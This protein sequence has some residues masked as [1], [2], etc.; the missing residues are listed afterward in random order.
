MNNKSK[1]LILSALTIF[2]VVISA[3]SW[4][5]YSGRINTYQ[6][7][8]IRNANNKPIDFK[9]Y[10]T[11]PFGRVF[12]FVQRD[13]LSASCYYSFCR[14]IEIRFQADNNFIN[15]N[16][17]IEI[18]NTK[19]SY[20]IIGNNKFIK[21]VLDRGDINYCKALFSVLQWYIFKLI[22]KI[23]FIAAIIFLLLLK[24]KIIT[25][26]IK[27]FMILLIQSIKS[28]I[29]NIINIVKKISENTKVQKQNII[30]V[31]LSL[32]NKIPF[33]SLTILF[34]IIALLPFLYLP[35]F[36]FPTPEEIQISANAIKSNFDY[37]SF[38]Y[39]IKDGRFFT[40][41][42]YVISPLSWHSIFGYRLML[43]I[44]MISLW[45]SI[46]FFLRTVFN[47][48][49]NQKK[50][51]EWTLLLIVMFTCL[52]PSVASGY[53]WL[54]AVITYLIPLI[55][56]LNLLSLIIINYNK[57]LSVLKLAV[58]SI[59]I[60]IICGSHEIY[61]PLITSI[62][63]LLTV[64]LFYNNNIN[65]W[66]FLFLFLLSLI[67]VYIVLSAPGH[68]NRI[69][70]NHSS[71][72]KIL[73]LFGIDN[74]FNAVKFAFKSVYESFYRY[75]YLNPIILFLSLLSIPTF[76]KIKTETAFLSRIININPLWAILACLL[77]M[78]LPVMPYFIVGEN[79]YLYMNRLFNIICFLFIFAWFYNI[80]VIIT[81]LKKHKIIQTLYEI[82]RKT[83]SIRLLKLLLIFF[84]IAYVFYTQNNI[85]VAYRD[86]ISGRISEYERQMSIRFRKTNS[87]LNNIYD[88]HSLLI[89]DAISVKPV[90]IHYQDYDITGYN[91]S[92]RE[93]VADY[94]HVNEVRYYSDTIPYKRPLFMKKN[95]VITYDFKSISINSNIPIFGSGLIPSFILGLYGTD[96]LT[97]NWFLYKDFNFGYSMYDSTL[98]IFSRLWIDKN[99]NE[100]IPVITVKFSNIKGDT[101]YKTI[102]D[103]LK[104]KVLEP[105]SFIAYDKLKLNHINSIDKSFVD[106]ILENRITFVLSS[107]LIKPAK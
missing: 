38:V 44:C 73:D 40:S 37:M 75:I 5:Y 9:V 90:S 26:S 58:F 63:F 92:F 69:Q 53:Y 94:F 77:L 2:F 72:R 78:I 62:L 59:F 56:L 50:I 32:F 22:F 104:P 55:V 106:A 8:I 99:I 85:Y 68:A 66:R 65:K 29:D 83:I 24:I 67:V 6:P 43:F 47:N 88:N 16:I 45:V 21:P 35:F 28:L 27:K 41:F 46:Y 86:I 20:Q 105:S 74:V 64:F 39:N 17:I 70:I 23:V 52:M 76:Y 57:K 61:I 91:N 89:V 12:P 42:L 98:R 80:L 93:G 19:Y 11:T 36:T 100:F 95:A 10:G 7:I 54:F 102:I 60:L 81:Y 87:P 4:L 96:T 18:G 1:I 103:T 79:S 48:V 3:F 14:Q 71:D 101:I 15:H 82:L 34:C 107:R 33:S 84:F 25:K 30:S 49:I 13:S 31:V 51:I 97:K